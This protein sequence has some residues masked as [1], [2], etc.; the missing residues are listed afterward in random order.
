A[1]LMR[2]GIS[3]VNYGYYY[4]DEFE[5]FIEPAFQS[6]RPDF[7]NQFDLSFVNEYRSSYLQNWHLLVMRATSLLV[8]FSP[9]TYVV[10]M[11]LALSALHI[12]FLYYLYLFCRVLL[13]AR[14]ALLAFGAYLFWYYTLYYCP[15]LLS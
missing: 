8:P 12:V 5:S 9:H 11:K 13:P 6:L 15:R 4:P 7:V 2:L 3:L 10:A 14:A 1:M